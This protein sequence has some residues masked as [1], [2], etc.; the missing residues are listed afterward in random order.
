[1]VR[2]KQKHGELRVQTYPEIYPPITMEEIEDFQVKV[3]NVVEKGLLED[4]K[5]RQF[6]AVEI[7]KALSQIA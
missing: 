4:P 6:K 3:R 2:L 1:M 5:R 7:E